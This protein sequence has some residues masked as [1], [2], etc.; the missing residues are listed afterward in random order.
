MPSVKLKKVDMVIRSMS[1]LVCKDAFCIRVINV[2]PTFHTYY[3][4]KNKTPL[5]IEG[6]LMWVN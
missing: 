6:V 1:I 5:M 2:D 3:T 4:L